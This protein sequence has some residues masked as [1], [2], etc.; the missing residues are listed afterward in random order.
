MWKLTDIAYF[1][2]AQA[3]EPTDLIV[4]HFQGHCQ[5]KREISIYKIIRIW[6]YR[7]DKQ[8]D[9]FIN[10]QSDNTVIS[11]TSNMEPCTWINQSGIPTLKHIV[12]IFQALAQTV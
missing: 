9:F 10:L 5:K 7:E 4:V 6:P 8:E 2:T 12:S 3:V 1:S 11:V